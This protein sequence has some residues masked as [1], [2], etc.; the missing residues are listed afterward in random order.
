MPNLKPEEIINI[1]GEKGKSLFCRPIITV[2]HQKNFQG[3]QEKLDNDLK[4]LNKTYDNRAFS[5]ICALI[6]EDELD[7]FLASWIKKYNYLKNKKDLTFSFKIDLAISLKL[8]PIKILNAIEPIRKIRNIFVHNI[9]IS[10]FKQVKEFD[11]KSFS[12]LYNKIKTFI[13]WNK[14][15]DKDTFRMLVFMVTLGL[16]IY[17][18]HTTK[19]RDYIW[20]SK[21]LTRIIKE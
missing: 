9:N 6:I 21:N 18:K 16:R 12:N 20:D 11:Y 4:M 8:I 17:S 1:E 7:N 13:F 3:I 15:D 19:V 10:T 14:D 2:V 5:I